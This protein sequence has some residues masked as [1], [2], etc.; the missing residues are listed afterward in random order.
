MLEGDLPRCGRPRTIES[1]KIVALTTGGTPEQATDWSRA[2]MAKAAGIS[3][4]SVGRIWK[5]H[6]LKPHRVTSV[7]GLP[8]PAT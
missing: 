5:R 8:V 1:K 6:G 3:A 2:L 7:F 4:S